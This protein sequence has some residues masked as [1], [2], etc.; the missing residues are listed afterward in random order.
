LN[1]LVFDRIKKRIVNFT[2]LD[3]LCVICIDKVT[4]KALYYNISRDEVIGF[5][6]I[7]CE[8]KFLP[9]YNAA[10]I[11][12][13][14]ICT[15]WKQ[16]IAYYLLNSTFNEVDVQNAIQEVIRRL[17]IIGLKVLVLVI[18][19]GKN[20]QN[21][22]KRLAIT[23]EKPFFYINGEYIHYLADPPHLIKATRKTIFILTIL[24]IM[25]I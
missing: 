23:P 10:V 8:K 19:M 15:S 1:D 3:K 22:T 9:A 11:M 6:N 18:D 24:N 14:D 21:M 17:Q 5:E 13:R 20:Y 7:G 16:P 25:I 2:S 12:I 4:L